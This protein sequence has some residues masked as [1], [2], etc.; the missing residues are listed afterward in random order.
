MKFALASITRD[1]NELISSKTRRVVAVCTKQYQHT[2]DRKIEEKISSNLFKITFI[3]LFL[4]QFHLFYWHSFLPSCSCQHLLTCLHFYTAFLYYAE[5]MLRCSLVRW[6]EVTRQEFLRHINLNASANVGTQ[7]DA[8]W[9]DSL[10]TSLDITAACDPLSDFTLVTS[11]PSP[12][13]PEKIVQDNYF[14]TRTYDTG[15]S[16]ELIFI[17]FACLMVHP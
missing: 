14:C 8:G 3:T 11:V 6:C 1:Q 12:S 9:I 15:H 17:K 5:R 2:C 16:F 10:P 7:S 13:C 4:Y